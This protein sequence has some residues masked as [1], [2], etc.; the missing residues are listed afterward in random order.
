MIREIS[1]TPTGVDASTNAAVFSVRRTAQAAPAALATPPDTVESLRAARDD[2]LAE[3]AAAR[4]ASAIAD[5]HQYAAA[6]RAEQDRAEGNGE[7]IIVL[8]TARR[9]RDAAAA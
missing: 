7:C 6:I 5:P 4:R 2:A 3:I 1:L 9:V 8:E